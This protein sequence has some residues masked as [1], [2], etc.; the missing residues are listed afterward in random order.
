[1]ANLIFILID[2]RKLL[3]MKKRE[4]DCLKYVKNYQKHDKDHWDWKYNSTAFAVPA[5]NLLLPCDT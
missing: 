5:C 3:R 1:M 2:A 4:K